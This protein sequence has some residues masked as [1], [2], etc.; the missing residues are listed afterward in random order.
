MRTVPIFGFPDLLANVQIAIRRQYGIF[1]QARSHLFL[2]SIRLPWL[3]SGT[4]I[5][6]NLARTHQ[7]AKEWQWLGQRAPNGQ[8]CTI[9]V[10]HQRFYFPSMIGQTITTCFSGTQ[11]ERVCFSSALLDPSHIPAFLSTGWKSRLHS[12]VLASSKDVINRW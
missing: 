12:P 9:R 10:H 4:I 7:L 11:Q 6:G 5:R 2:M 3:L 8:S 1:N